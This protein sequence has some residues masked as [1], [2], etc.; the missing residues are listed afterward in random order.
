MPSLTSMAT[1]LAKQFTRSIPLL[2]I[3]IL[4][5]PQASM[6]AKPQ[7]IAPLETPPLGERWFS[8][9][10]NGERVG[11]ARVEITKTA[12]G[13]RITSDG[14]AKMLVLGFSREAASREQYELSRNL[15]LKSFR[16]EQTIDKSPMNIAGTVSGSTVR[17]T[18]ETK[19]GTSEKTLK[20]KGTIFPPPA[21]NLLPLVQ[22]F[23]PGKKYRFQILDTEAMKLKDVEVKVIGIESRGGAETVHMQ[24]DLYTF[25]DNDVWTDR[26]GDTIEESVRDGMIVTRAEKPEEAKQFLMEDSVAKRDMILDFSLVPVDK[27]LKN[28]ASLKKLTIEF[29]GYRP[30]M[31]LSEGPGQSAVRPSADTARFT[32]TNPLAQSD[33]SPLTAEARSRY[34]SA[35]PRI[36]SEDAELI[37]VRQKLLAKSGSIRESAEIL[38]NWAATYLNDSVKDSHTAKEAFTAK[39]GNCQSH[40]RLY[41]SLARGAGIPSR[42]VSGL[43][44]AENKGFLYH[45]WVESYIDGW[46]ALDP[47]FGQFPAD[48]SHIRLVEGDEPA[49]L[50]P[51]SGIIGRIKG[52]VVDME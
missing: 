44:Y 21:V 42:M 48:I 23:V 45:S 41:L 16:V 14:S 49:D 10:M 39:E 1:Y 46:I 17:A 25:V 37:A 47:T 43:Y 5:A 11:F 28:P 40:A 15:S 7:K 2:I 30:Q 18:I 33:A 4:L 26:N 12:D 31:E 38:T 50:A 20:G 27:P 34:L 22:G 19:G 51:L 29:T 3:T 13:Y 52:K 32:M 36:N 35:T 6:A 24:N 8:I 9:T